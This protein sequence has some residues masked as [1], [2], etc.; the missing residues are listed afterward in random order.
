MASI[1]LLVSYTENVIGYSAWQAGPA[2]P[3]DDRVLYVAAAVSGTLATRVPPRLLICASCAATAVGLTLADPLLNGSASWVALLPVIIL[4][5]IGLGIFNA[6]RAYLAAGVAEPAAAGAASGMSET[7]QQGGMAIGIAAFGALFQNRVIHA[8][9]A[10]NS[11][12]HWA[13]RPA[14]SPSK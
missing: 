8:F 11:D 1:F 5:G 10:S 12:A 13:A 6:V 3:A 4:L 9:D 2:V 7:F 14:R